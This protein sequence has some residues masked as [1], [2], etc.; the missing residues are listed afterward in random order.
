M[1]ALTAAEAAWLASDL[2]LLRQV[3]QPD[4]RVIEYREAGPP[5]APAVVL[6]HGLTRRTMT[7]FLYGLTSLAAVGFLVAGK[8]GESAWVR[9]AARR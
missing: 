7:P 6:L 8:K 1:S 9:A 5:G 3:S 4:G 2:P